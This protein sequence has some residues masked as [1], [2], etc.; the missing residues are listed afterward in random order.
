MS[1]LPLTLHGVPA[2]ARPSTALWVVLIV[3]VVVGSGY[4]AWSDGT[5]IGFGLALLGPAAAVL[6]VLGAGFF[7]KTA[8]RLSIEEG[9]LRLESLG[10]LGTNG[11]VPVEDVYDYRIERGAGRYNQM[12]ELWTR[13]GP[14]PIQAGG[15]DSRELEALGD[16]LKAL[17]EEIRGPED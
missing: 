15:H 3:P 9:T 1:L 12:L 10:G 8:T 17:A 16:E 4:L 13:K 2:S 14:L 11:E 6:T 5:V 7:Q